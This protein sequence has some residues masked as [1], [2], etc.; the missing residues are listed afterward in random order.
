MFH[1]FVF[2]EYQEDNWH[3][4]STDF[5]FVPDLIEDG[6]T[7]VAHNIYGHDLPL[8]SKLLGITYDVQK[9]LFEGRHVQLIDSLAWSRELWPDRP[10]GHGLDAWG[11]KLGILKP[12]VKNWVEGDTEM[13]LHRC[14]EDVKINEAV[15]EKLLQE[16]RIEI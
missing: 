5:T 1:C 13:Y 9:E 15:F 3:E 8:M 16:A 4:F 12:V 2:K 7:L 11:K 6:D 10:Y 14:R